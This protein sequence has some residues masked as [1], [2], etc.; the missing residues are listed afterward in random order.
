M[1]V[2][3]QYPFIILLRFILL[4]NILHNFYF[5]FISYPLLYIAVYV[6]FEKIH[7]LGQ[8]WRPLNVLHRPNTNTPITL[9]Q[10]T[11]HQ[12]Q[13][14]CCVLRQYKTSQGLLCWLFSN[15]TCIVIQQ[16]IFSKVCF[17]TRCLI[18]FDQLY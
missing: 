6:L 18:W 5:N 14:I 11:N 7:I 16:G 2:H 4:F 1:V 17:Q 15:R 8:Q 3:S 12:I 13:C 10:Y 9:H